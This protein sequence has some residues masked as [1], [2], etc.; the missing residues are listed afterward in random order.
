VDLIERSLAAAG[1][2]V[3]LLL[4]IGFTVLVVSG[5]KWL[6]G[7]REA[8]KPHSRFQ[9]QLIML[10]TIFVAGLAI[11]VA[12]PISDTLRGQLLS[13]IGIL[14][15]AAIALSSTTFIGN[16]MAGIMLRSIRNSR[17]GDFITV[18][19][20]TGRITEMGLLHTEIQTEF[21]DLVT[22]PNL[23]MV[24]NPVKVVRRSGTIIT[25]EVSLGYD[26]PH[27]QVAELLC[28]AAEKAGLTDAFVQVRELGDYS[29]TYRVAGLLEDVQS[30][31]S[32]RSALRIATL[33]ALHHNGIE[34]VS[35]SFVNQRRQSDGQLMIP[36]PSR[37]STATV[38]TQPQAEEIAFDKAEAA[39]SVE[40][41][42]ASIEKLDEELDA[43]AKDKIISE[44]DRQRLESRRAWLLD[45]LQAAE[46]MQ[47]T[48]D[49]G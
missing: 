32:S 41:L 30:L 47:A 31:I 25:S 43:A 12:L 45:R 13:L 15:S 9:H 27:S 42:R 3:P 7:R 17:P 28:D 21:R 19:D 14:L 1:S 34:V 23:H 37:I 5:T 10:C 46:E 40:E 6:L 48:E 29:V 22:L 24:T 33:D 35:P 20:L 18:G 8:N 16:I 39:A 11:I 2:F 4:V 26:V 36:A 38:S 49:D 44:A